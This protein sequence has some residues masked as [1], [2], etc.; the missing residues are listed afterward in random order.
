MKMGRSI[1][2]AAVAAG[3]LALGSAAFAQDAKQPKVETKPGTTQEHRGEHGGHGM[4]RM[5]EHGGCHGQ[6]EPSGGGKPAGEHEHS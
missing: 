1:T 3:A 6:Q 2:L 4:R 5:S